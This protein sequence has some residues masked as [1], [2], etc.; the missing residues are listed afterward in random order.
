MY[1]MYPNPYF[2]NTPMYNPY[3]QY[4]YYNPPMHKPDHFPVNNDKTGNINDFIS[5]LN[6]RGFIVQE[7]ELRYFDILKFCSIGIFEDCFGNHAG[8]PYAACILPPAPNQDPAKGQ[9]PP[10][11]Y[12]P[13]DP[14][15][16]PANVTYGVPGIT[17][18]LRPDEAIVLIGKTPPPAYYFGFRSYIGLA[19]NMPNKEYDEDTTVGS[20]AITLG[21]EYTGEYH[22]LFNSLGDQLNNFNL[23]TSNTPQ[24]RYGNPFLS[25]TVIIST[26]D[27]GINKQMREALN[28]SGF[29]SDIMNDDNIPMGLVNM[30]LEKGKDT[31]MFIMR[32]IVWQNQDMGT[33]Y[34]NN[35]KNY[36]KVLRITP[37]RP[38]T[39]LN[40]WP[41]PALKPRETCTTEFKVLQN[42]RNELAYLRNEII[43]K[44]GSEEYDHIELNL[45]LNSN[46]LIPDNY[47]SIVLD[48]DTIGDNRDA[49]YTRTEKFQLNSDDDFVVL[50]GV[51]HEQTGKALI[52]NASFYG[53]ELYNGV[54]VAQISIRFKN[55]A[56]QY[57]PEGYKNQKYYYVC[58]FTRKADGEGV[59]VPYSTGNPC[60]KAY[61]VDNNKD[62]FIA[63][64]I[65]VDKEA[66]VGPA[67]FDVIW[68]RAILFTKKSKQ[69]DK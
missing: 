31:F 56:E 10:V 16:Y 51:N 19:E 55:S 23:W 12:N 53:Y 25:N 57:F 42:A 54:A 34:L 6:R 49:T 66:L 59:V 22:R 36:F 26:A 24:G 20:K 46:M 17:Y 14:N 52:N 1:K 13:N 67:L 64:R 68:D 60:G 2:I 39:H 62:A 8:A 15:N 50:Y 29:S 32:A 30:G 41:V 3:K 63:F 38:V 65:Y 48:Y 61:G 33:Q 35:L 9:R 5:T 27:K 40:P 44:Y 43:E 28:V 11:G 18:K 47:Q 69:N 58:K 4:P 7:G 37:K 21:D 45:D